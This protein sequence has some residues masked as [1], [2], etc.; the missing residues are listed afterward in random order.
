MS[1]AVL[2]LRVIM[3]S[4][5]VRSDTVPRRLG[6]LNVGLPSDQ[7]LESSVSFFAPSTL[8]TSGESACRNASH[9]TNVLIALAKNNILVLVQLSGEFRLSCRGRHQDLK[10]LVAGQASEEIND[11]T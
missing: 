3:A 9:S 11:P 1:V 10:C 8:S 4:N 6:G 5:A 7:T 2:S